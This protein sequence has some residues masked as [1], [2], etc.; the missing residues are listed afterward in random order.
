MNILKSSLE[1]FND[2]F[3]ISDIEIYFKKARPDD[4]RFKNIIKTIEVMRFLLF[5]I[6]LSIYLIAV[7]IAVITGLLMVL[8]LILDKT[9]NYLH[10]SLWLDVAWFNITRKE[11]MEVI[12]TESTSEQS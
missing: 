12:E 2:T 6:T 11:A 3:G 9:F 5:P 10:D 4:V 1:H 8:G 7:V